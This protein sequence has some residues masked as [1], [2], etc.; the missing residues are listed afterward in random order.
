M[1]EH[2]EAFREL[3][4]SYGE[5]KAYVAEFPATL[6][7][8]WGRSNARDTATVGQLWDIVTSP[9]FDILR[10]SYGSTLFPT[11]V[12]W[13]EEA[14]TFLAAVNPKVPPTVLFGRFDNQSRY[15][16][17]AGEELKVWLAGALAHGAGFWECTFVGRHGAEFLDRRNEDIVAAYYTLM[18]NNPAYFRDVRSVAEI[19]VEHSHRSQDHV[20]SDDPRDD[21]SVPHMRGVFSTLFA[22]HQPFDILPEDRITPE[23]LARYR[24]VVL[25]NAAMLDDRACAAIRAYVE[26]GGGIVATYATALPARRHRALRLRARRGLRGDLHRRGQRSDP[27]RVHA[28]PRAQRADRRPRGH[29][30]GDEYRPDPRGPPGR[31]YRCAHDP[32]ARGPAATARAWLAGRPRDPDPGDRDPRVRAPAGRCCSPAIPTSSQRSPGTPTTRGSLPTPSRGRVAATRWCGRLRRI[33]CTSACSGRNPGAESS[34]SS[35]TAAG[36]AARSGR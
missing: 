1:L 20:G 25:P 30:G 4:K 36:R 31:G 23:H 24:V 15:T 10:G 9:T 7:V 21:G 22:E 17:V 18:A 16:T 28:D 27:V 26:G 32:R 11:P 35:T 33:A 19:A 3:V 6:D 8:S 5:D 14:A 29:A 13:A 12:W 2:A 34:I